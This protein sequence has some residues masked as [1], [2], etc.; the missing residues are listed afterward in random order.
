MEHPAYPNLSLRRLGLRV[1][2]LGLRLKD[3]CSGQVSAFASSGLVASTAP[4]RC[5]AMAMATALCQASGQN[6]LFRVEDSGFRV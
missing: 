5:A 3:P 4:W 2:G 1:S 6:L